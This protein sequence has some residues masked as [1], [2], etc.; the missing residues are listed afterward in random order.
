V[1]IFIIY[2]IRQLKNNFTQKNAPKI[3][4]QL[5]DMQLMTPIQPVEVIEK[6]KK[7]E[8]VEEKSKALSNL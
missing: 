4:L 1:L 8:E 7:E 3:E 2:Q 6:K 5:N